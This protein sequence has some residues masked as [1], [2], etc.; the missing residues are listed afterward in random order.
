MYLRAK[1][2]EEGE[3]VSFIYQIP[4]PLF[5]GCPWGINS[6]IPADQP[7][8]L[9]SPKGRLPVAEATLLGLE[10]ELKRYSTKEDP[11]MIST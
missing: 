8:K 2:L 1:P 9:P 7:F 3:A 5:E 10:V 11:E 6:L 4:S